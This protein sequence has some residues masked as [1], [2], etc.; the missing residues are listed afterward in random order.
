MYSMSTRLFLKT[1]P[2]DFI[3]RIRRIHKTLTGIRALAVP[4]RLPVPV[5]RPLRRA[6]ALRRTRARECTATGFRM[7]KPSL[8]NLRMF[9]RELAL[10]ISLFSFGS[11]QTLFRPH[12]RTAAAKRFCNPKELDEPDD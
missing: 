11:S 4:L 9:C 8:I 10:E 7:I 3:T 5:C 6:S 12:L 2:L 1:L